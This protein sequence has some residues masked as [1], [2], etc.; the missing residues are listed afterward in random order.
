MAL[1][2]TVTLEVLPSLMGRPE[3]VSRTSMDPCIY[4]NEWPERL[5]RTAGRVW[6]PNQTDGTWD[7]TREAES[8][9]APVLIVHGTQDRIPV[10]G[11]RDWAAHL[12]R[13]R[14]VELEGVGHLPWLEAPDR[15]FTE[16][17]AFLRGK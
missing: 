16:V 12:P 10:E 2:A 5:A 11:G 15:F 4:S 14:M 9:R 13:S 1:I 3:A 17:D 8:V 7:F 6:P